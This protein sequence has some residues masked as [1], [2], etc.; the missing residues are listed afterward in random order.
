VGKGGGLVTDV[1]PDGRRLAIIAQQGGSHVSADVYVTDLEGKGLQTVWVDKPDEWRDARAL[2]SPD[3]S[4][5][6][7]HHNFTRGMLKT[8]IYHG[9][10]IARLD[11]DGKWT[12][13]LQ[14]T[15]EAFV[16]PLAWSPREGLLLCARMHDSTSKMPAA[17]LY[18]MDEQFRTV[19]TLF[20]LESTPWQP[21]QRELGRLAD[22]GLVPDD[23]AVVTER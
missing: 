17:T 10:G 14:P 4:R 18:L 3:G 12:A 20:E 13:R 19:R 8:P 2:W 5:I 22:W 23:V 11:A 15:P 1:S 21:G 6:A 7:W 16:T 9:V